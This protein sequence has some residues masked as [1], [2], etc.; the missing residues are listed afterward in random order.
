MVFTILMSAL[1]QK[2]KYVSISLASLDNKFREGTVM[3]FGRIF[4]IIRSTW[5]PRPRGLD[6]I[7]RMEVDLAVAKKYT[8]TLPEEGNLDLIDKLAKLAKPF[9]KKIDLKDPP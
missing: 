6:R 2:W 9:L 8:A 5:S 7:R 1:A 3:F 4:E